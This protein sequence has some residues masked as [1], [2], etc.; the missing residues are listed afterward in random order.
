ME[1]AGALN[2]QA[3]RNVKMVKT[4]IGLIITANVWIILNY[5]DVMLEPYS[6]NSLGEVVFVLLYV[7]VPY[8]LLLRLAIKKG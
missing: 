6:P 1:T 7:F 5:V 3:G 4:D 2:A 8:I